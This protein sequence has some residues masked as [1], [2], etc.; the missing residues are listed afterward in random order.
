MFQGMAPQQHP[1]GEVSLCENTFL[2]PNLCSAGMLLYDDGC[3]ARLG[4]DAG[5]R[6]TSLAAQ[7]PSAALTHSCICTAPKMH[8]SI[9]KT[10]LISNGL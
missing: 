1:A 3:R 9:A 5:R 2:T 10:P 4:R 8:L 6:G 7:E